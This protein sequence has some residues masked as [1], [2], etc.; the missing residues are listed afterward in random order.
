[1]SPGE[2]VLRVE[3]GSKRRGGA[4]GSLEFQLGPV[5]VEIPREAWT[6][7][8]GPSGAGK[9]TLLQLLAGLD[10]PDHGR[11]WMFG[12]D[13]TGLPEAALTEI[14]RAKLGLVYQS[15]H[16]LEH[17]PVWQ[18]VTAK[19]APAG[20]LP[21]ER[22]RRAE[23]ALRDLDLP[24]CLDRLPRE[25]STGEQQRVALAR[26]IVD[27]PEVLLCDE[28]T[29]NLDATTGDAIA[30]RL[31]ALRQAGTTIVLSTHD[32]GLIALADRRYELAGGRLGA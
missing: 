13:V 6:V 23:E 9:T 29:S 11:L 32:P 4:R 14:R 22:R 19:L 2:P 10:R 30:A 24:S 27:R 5:T 26:A 12:R 21:R 16:F 31:Q 3:E 8:T 7:L 18:N 15:F 20:V 25:L 1:M 17:L 28:P